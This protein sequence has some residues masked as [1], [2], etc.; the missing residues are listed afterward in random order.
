MH[1]IQLA[2]AARL[3]RLSLLEREAAAFRQLCPR[4]SV[5]VRPEGTTLS[6]GNGVFS[7]SLAD[8]EIGDSWS[9]NQTKTADI[10]LVVLNLN[11][12]HLFLTK[13]CN[14]KP[15]RIA[16][17]AGPEEG[18][19]I[20]PPRIVLDTLLDGLQALDRVAKTDADRQAVLDFVAAARALLD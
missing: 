19:L 20:E 13:Y 9:V 2:Q 11:P 6:I 8:L 14:P 12:M 5:Q 3:E 18:C 17:G 16:F 10:E 15:T 4:I 1:A 7:E